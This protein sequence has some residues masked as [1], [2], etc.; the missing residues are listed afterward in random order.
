MDELQLKVKV[1]PLYMVFGAILAPVS[2]RPADA[3]RTA[4]SGVFRLQQKY[5]TRFAY[6]MPVDFH[7]IR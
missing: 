7:L 2:G 3:I 6:G 5:R 1:L 4:R